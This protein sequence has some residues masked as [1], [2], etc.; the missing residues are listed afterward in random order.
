M[1]A[2]RWS[3]VDQG[4]AGSITVAK[5]MTFATSSTSG[6]G[7]DGDSRTSIT[8]TKNKSKISSS[9]QNGY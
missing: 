8:T 6:N 1:P 5:R 2:V 7:C 4:N 3:R 9:R